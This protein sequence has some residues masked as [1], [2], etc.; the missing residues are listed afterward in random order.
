MI[1]TPNATSEDSSSKLHHPKVSACVDCKRLK[2]K[3]VRSIPENAN[4]PCLRC[5]KKNMECITMGSLKRHNGDSAAAAVVQQRKRRHGKGVSKDEPLR[6]QLLFSWRLLTSRDDRRI[7][8][9]EE[10]NFASLARPHNNV[11]KLGL[12]TEEQILHR[13]SIYK[14]HMYPKFPVV[15][16]PVDVGYQQLMASH[17]ILFHTVL[18][19]ASLMISDERQLESSVILHNMVLRTVIDE[20]IVVSVKSLELLKSLVLLTVW[21][22]ESELYHQQRLYVLTTLSA[23]VSYDLG[24]AVRPHSENCLAPENSL[25]TVV[26]VHVS[27]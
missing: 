27:T 26:Q 3:C 4:S 21:Y 9:L 20:I 22:N 12:L 1:N 13:L 2:V 24:M 25:Y 18:D 19:I 15:E 7:Q 8:L 10:Y 11:L 16:L 17:P 5:I 6:N 23:S 14:E